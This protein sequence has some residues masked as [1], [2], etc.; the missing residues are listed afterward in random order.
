MALPHCRGESRRARFPIKYR[1]PRLWLGPQ[2]ADRL[3]LSRFLGAIVPIHRVCSRTRNPRCRPPVESSHTKWLDLKTYRLH[4]R[5]PTNLWTITTSHVLSWIGQDRERRN[6][7]DNCQVASGSGK[8]ARPLVFYAVRCRVKSTG[9][10]TLDLS[11]RID[12]CK[13]TTR[14]ASPRATP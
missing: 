12:R 11:P 13:S 8:D 4:G 7:R 14:C 9:S 5:K 3:V 2:I 6:C 1:L 10:P